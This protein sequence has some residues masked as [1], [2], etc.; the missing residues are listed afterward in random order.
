MSHPPLAP[1]SASMNV[2]VD[3]I[4][5]VQHGVITTKQLLTVISSRKIDTRVA[6][7]DLLRIRRSVYRLRGAPI[8]WHQMMI[9]A[10]L[11]KNGVAHGQAAGRLW[12]L[13]GCESASVEV[14]VLRTQSH[15]MSVGVLHSTE[16]TTQLTSVRDR[17]PV[18]GIERTIIELS[19]TM[20]QRRVGEA[21]DDAVQRGLTTVARVEDV[22]DEMGS[23]GRKKTSIMKTVLEMRSDDVIERTRWLH[24]RVVRV[25][26]AAGYDDFVVEHPITASGRDRSLDIAW[27]QYRLAIE[28]DG[29]SFHRSRTSFDEDKVRQNEITIAG[30]TILPV[31]SEMADEFILDCVRQAIR[32]ATHSPA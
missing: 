11:A 18:T 7:G 30:W 31:T 19:E 22:L 25:L 17:I 20:L 28:V 1:L 26:K 24:R 5:R 15:R 6:R 10:V 9:A 3:R 16:T 29:Y 12:E 2:E 14:L 32:L 21:L 23:V 13:S 4:A 27:P 8:T